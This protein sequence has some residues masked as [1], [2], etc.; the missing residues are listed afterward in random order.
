MESGRY[1][2]KFSNQLIYTYGDMEKILTKFTGKRNSS[3]DKAETEPEAF[4]DDKFSNLI[5]TSYKSLIYY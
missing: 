5:F 2:S 4:A 1:I 3:L